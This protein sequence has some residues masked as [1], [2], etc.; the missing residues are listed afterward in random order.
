MSNKEGQVSELQSRTWFV[1]GKAPKS[2]KLRESKK[3]KTAKMPLD[4]RFSTAR[5]HLGDTQ[6]WSKSFLR[7]N[8]KEFWCQTVRTKPSEHRRYRPKYAKV[9]KTSRYEPA[10]NS[11]FEKAP[12]EN[13]LE[14]G[15]ET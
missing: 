2:T 1:W 8:M 4:R 14:I 10:Q 9:A 15:H 3:R 6:K 12:Q 5:K 7:T 11:D 13:H